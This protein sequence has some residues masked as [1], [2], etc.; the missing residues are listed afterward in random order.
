VISL[1]V[2][3]IHAALGL[4]FL[5]VLAFAGD[6]AAFDKGRPRTGGPHSR[7]RQARTTVTRPRQPT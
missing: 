2:E 6:I 5:A 1:P 3:L 7:R 4:V